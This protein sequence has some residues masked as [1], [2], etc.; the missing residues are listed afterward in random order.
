MKIKRGDMVVVI[1]GDHAGR[2]PHRVTQVLNGGKQ[3]LVEGINRVFKHVKRGHPKSPQGGRLNLETPIDAS[4]VMFYC[5]SCNR[6][7]RVGFR[8][9][10][11]GSKE[12]F[13]KSCGTGL[14]AVGR[15]K[16]ARA[17]T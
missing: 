17:A 7:V 3:L 4:K 16:P 10:A 1:G 12:R 6:G 2:T 8:V 13:C 5:G 11:G 15:A 9:Q 14:G